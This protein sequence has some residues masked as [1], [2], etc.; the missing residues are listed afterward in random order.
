MKKILLSSLLITASL[1][2][3]S[4]LGQYENFV[5]QSP[6]KNVETLATSKKM[7]KVGLDYF[8]EGSDAYSVSVINVPVQALVTKNVLL[9]ASLPYKIVSPDVGS[10][11][12]GLSDIMIGAGYTMGLVGSDQ[13]RQVFGLRYNI[14]GDEKVATAANV[15]T[16]DLYWDT[17]GKIGQFSV[18]S[19]VLL[20][21]ALDD[22]NNKEIGSSSLLSI[23]VGHD[24]LLTEELQTNAIISWYSKYSDET[25]FG[26]TIPNSSH[27]LVDLTL[28]WNTLKLKDTPISFGAK[29]PLYA[30]DITGQDLKTYTFFVNA[31]GLF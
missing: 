7:F 11:E 26:H 25:I 20:S 27:N 10:S 3:Q 18:G 31:A 4:A 15:S 9:E 14:A 12:S 16:F 1:Q 30:T 22:V 6:A 24:C 2:A 23:N 21:Y 13:A 5:I 8:Y 28:K 19:G 17:L 29:I